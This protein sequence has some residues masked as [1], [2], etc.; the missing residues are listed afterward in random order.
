MVRGVLAEAVV[1]H[2]IDVTGAFLMS[3]SKTAN[4]AI[5]KLACENA[6]LRGQ[7]LATGVILAQLLQSIAKTQLNPHAFATKITKNAQD[8]VSAFTPEAT[9]AHP[10]LMKNA[11]LETVKLYEEQIRSVLPI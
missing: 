8:A 9:E 1:P 3:D 11:A 4:D 5:A 7:I 6:K 10:D 2:T